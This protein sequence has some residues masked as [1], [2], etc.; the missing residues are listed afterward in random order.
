[1]AD[2]RD[3]ALP[4]H[5]AHKKL[6]CFSEIEALFVNARDDL[7]VGEHVAVPLAPSAGRK[8]GAPT[9][10]GFHAVSCIWS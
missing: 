7:G 8:A 5:L 9:E 6:G 2:P 10:S 4:A 3:T 1:M